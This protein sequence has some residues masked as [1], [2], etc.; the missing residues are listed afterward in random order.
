MEDPR[1]FSDVEASHK[2]PSF[3]GY[4]LDLK[5]GQVQ[6][7]GKISPKHVMSYASRNFR[8]VGLAVC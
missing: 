6:L 5:K 7:F 8:F 3:I 4:R 1:A 2:A